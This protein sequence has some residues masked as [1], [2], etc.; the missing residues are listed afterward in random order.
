MNLSIIVLNQVV[1]MFLIIL[2]GVLM[3]KLKL[4][5]VSG[6]KEMSKILLDV[7]NSTVIFLSY[8]RKFE[9]ELLEGL[10]KAAILSVFAFLIIM[11]LAYLFIPKKSKEKQLERFS[12]I[13]SNCSFMGI[14]L[15]NALFGFEGVFYLTAFLTVF[16]ILV[17][18]HGVMQI[19]ETKNLKSIFSALR[20]P[21]IIAITI[22]VLS[23]LSRAILPESAIAVMENE[24]LMKTL[25]YI[26]AI[27]TP[28]AMIIAGST[29]AQVNALQA[30]KNL[31]IYWV[32]LVRLIIIPFVLVVIFNFIPFEEKIKISIIVA[33][34]APTATI[35]TLFSLNYNKNYIYA[36]EIF[37]IS[38]ILSIITIPLVITF[39]EFFSKI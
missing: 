14:P 12:C 28:L 22:G 31:K 9:K 1:I 15:I 27:N 36:S 6:S 29:I 17:W 35:A 4:I 13:Y 8:Q 39:N 10:A 5:T 11:L 20:S 21:S 37:A 33:A 3:Y 19:S 25:G 23:F 16:N 7:V 30:I 32:A 26:A 34:S 2:L 18:T 38:T 24:I